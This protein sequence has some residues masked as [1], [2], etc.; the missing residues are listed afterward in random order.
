MSGS[1]MVIVWPNSDGTFTLSQRTGT[2]HVLPTVDSNPS[3][4]ATK[5]L[6]AS[7]VRGPFFH[8]HDTGFDVLTPSSI[9]VTGS[10]PKFAFTMPLSGSVGSEYII[11]AFGTTNPGSSSS[12]ASFTQHFDMGQT[13]LDLSKSLG[14]PTSSGS[15]PSSTGGSGNDNDNNG[16]GTSLPLTSTDRMIIAHGILC[17]L[18]FMFFLPLGSLVARYFRTS[19]TAWFKAHQTIQS[20][21]AGPIIIVGWS[22]GVAVVANG[23]GPHFYNKHTV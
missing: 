23:G 19:T 15:T 5:E 4:L 8:R 3:P 14:S 18:G 9:Q 13:S 12:D 21:I 2:G 17:V 7:D 1:K 6:S 20:L 11:W 16:G 22:L 10:S